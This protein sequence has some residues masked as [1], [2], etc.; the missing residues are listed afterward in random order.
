MDALILAGGEN[1]RL[2]VMKGFLRINRKRIIEFNIEL[3]NGI[4]DRVIISTNN[5]EICFYLGVPMVGDIMKYRGPMVGILSVLIATEAS[6]VFVVACDMPFIKSELIRYIVDKYKTQNIA[7]PAQRMAGGQGKGRIDSHRGEGKGRSES[8]GS[9]QIWDAVIP[10]FGRKTQP[11]LG[12][13][14]KKIAGIME[15]SIKH[16][17]RSLR[18]FLKK[19]D[20]LYIEE[21]EV[22]AID[23]EGSSFVN[24]NTIEDY[25]RERLAIRGL[26]RSPKVNHICFRNLE[27]KEGGNVCLV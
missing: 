5:P 26:G 24:I 2:P 15:E 14:S 12:I 7:S 16:G 23:P 10:I 1:K 21:E 11:L 4:F 8:P 17:K 13:Y 22:K 6:E 25:K 19:I 18:R 20:V 3:L 9:D 27:L